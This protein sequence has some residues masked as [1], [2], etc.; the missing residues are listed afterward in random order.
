M[1]SQTQIRQEITNKIV[2]ALEQ[3]IL[4]WRRPWKHSGRHQNAFSKRPY[5][6]VNPWLLELHAMRHGF[7]SRRWA[8][9]NQWKA[10]GCTVTK[11]RFTQRRA[12]LMLGAIAWVKGSSGRSTS[13]ATTASTGH[14]ARRHLR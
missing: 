13:A 6:G 3:N 11:P 12:P 14:A 10:E 4:P 8:T 1:P 7:T 9:F 2:A 5:S